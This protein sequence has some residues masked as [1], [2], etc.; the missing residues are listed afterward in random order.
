[1]TGWSLKNMTL[2]M[3]LMSLSACGG[4]TVYQGDGF[5]NPDEIA[6]IW[7][8]TWRG[9]KC[10]IVL[11][12]RLDRGNIGKM[13][14]FPNQDCPKDIG[15]LSTWEYQGGRFLVFDGKEQRL[16]VFRESAR[17]DKSSMLKLTDK[18]PLSIRSRIWYAVVTPW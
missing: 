7:R 4:G 6:G 10:D 14:L 11:T 13:R 8:A 16:V 12:S 3:A 1:M 18:R 2:A 9:E 5:H 17:F 15:R